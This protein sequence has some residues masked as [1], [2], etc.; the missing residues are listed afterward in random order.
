IEEN[1]LVHNGWRQGTQSDRTGY[2]HNVYTASGASGIVIRNNISSQASYYGLKLNSG[3]TVTGNLLAR[4]SYSLYMEKDTTATDN[5]ITEGV[6][7]GTSAFAVGIETQISP[8]ATIRHNLI[9]KNTATGTSGNFG[10]HLNSAAAT[11]T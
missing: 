3:G 11:F 1:V 7:F 2:N 4:N 5:V 8:S 6:N 9:L 10:I